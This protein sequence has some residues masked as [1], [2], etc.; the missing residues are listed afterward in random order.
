MGDK[1]WKIARAWGLQSVTAA[2][3][4]DLGR[5]RTLGLGSSVHHLYLLSERGAPCFPGQAD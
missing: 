4:P 3:R 5:A 1:G 2:L